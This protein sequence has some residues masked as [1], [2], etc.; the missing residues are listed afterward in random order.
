MTYYWVILL[1][2]HND[3][4]KIGSNKA[5]TEFL[6]NNLSVI[7][8]VRGYASIQ[9]GYTE[10]FNSASFVVECNKTILY[11]IAIDLQNNPYIEDN[12]DIRHGN[13]SVEM[14]TVAQYGFRPT[15]IKTEM[16]FIS[17]RSFLKSSAMQEFNKGELNIEFLIRNFEDQLIYVSE[18]GS[19]FIQAD[20]NKKTE[21]I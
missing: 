6:R 20:D 12:D 14:Q 4:K 11:K 2:S 16:V 18:D 10:D 1:R 17:L 19:K 15:S 9:S 8:G 13:I 21:P 3:G 7:E 5:Y